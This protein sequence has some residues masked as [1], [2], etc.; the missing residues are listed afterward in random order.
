MQESVFIE[1]GVEHTRVDLLLFDHVWLFKLLHSLNQVS[2]PLINLAGF[3]IEDV[4]EIVIGRRIYLFWVLRCSYLFWEKHC[5]LL[6]QVTDHDAALLWDLRGVRIVLRVVEVWRVFKVL[7][8][9][10]E[11]F[12][13]QVGP[14]KDLLFLRL[15]FFHV[16]GQQLSLCHI[17]Q[18]LERVSIFLIQIPRGHHDMLIYILDKCLDKS[19]S[20]LLDPLLQPDV[21]VQKVS[22]SSQNAQTNCKVEIITVHNFDQAVFD[23]LSDIK[24]SA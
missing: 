24:N 23:F 14:F 1:K 9:H 12:F 22:F 2:Y 3:R 5:V 16:R 18:F 21:I 11:A 4:L 15:Q 6:D 19:R 7:H 8:C 10:A 17:S 20:D 13:R